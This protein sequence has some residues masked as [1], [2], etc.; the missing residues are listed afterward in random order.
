MYTPPKGSATRAGIVILSLAALYAGLSSAT[1]T[2]MHI[3]QNWPSPPLHRVTAGSIRDGV[4]CF[5]CDENTTFGG[6]E[7]HIMGDAIAH[8]NSRDVD[9][10]G[11]DARRSGR[12]DSGF[13]IDNKNYC[14]W[15]F[16][17]Y[18][19][20]GEITQKITCPDEK[21]TFAKKLLN[22]ALVASMHLEGR[23]VERE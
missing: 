6:R 13:I 4:Y 10:I 8:T 21:T 14:T 12:F 22:E 9:V 11:F 3:A 16:R 2:A 5:S 18:G 7:C 20:D 23:L 19:R 17:T 15:G 1:R